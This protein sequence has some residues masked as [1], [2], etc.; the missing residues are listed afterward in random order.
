MSLRSIEEFDLKSKNL[1]LRLDLNV[2]LNEGE[3]TDETRIMAALPTIQY[4]IDKGAKIVL[5]SH[6]GRPKTDEDRKK[7]SLQPVAERLGELLN[8]EVLLVEEPNGDA[9]KALLSN[10]KPNQLILLENLR[11]IP[12][13]TKNEKS[14]S[15][16]WAQFTDVYIN[17]AFGASHREHAS[18]VGLPK[19][20]K[21]HGV[22]FLIKKEVEMLNKVLKGDDKPFV[23]VLGGAK[24][25]DKITV[26]EALVNK[27]DT[28]IIG[29]AMAYTFLAAKGIC[30]GRSLVEK[31]KIHLA[32]EL[33]NRFKVRGKELLLPMDH[34]VVS[35]IEKPGTAL[36]TEND[37]IKDGYMGVDIGP[38]TMDYFCDVIKNAGMVFW[39]GPMGIFETPEYSKGTF[40]IAEAMANNTG[41]T[42]VG[43]GDSA[44]A[45][46]KSGFS[47]KVTHVSTGGGASLEYIE[48]GHLPGIDILK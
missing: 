13:E 10:L 19:L 32:K 40:A 17:D 42:I 46:A 9:P 34:L 5:A 43:G 2:P 29:G 31:D 15:E 44:A 38:K 37:N 11:F 4:A 27:V 24:V 1:F 7:L 48:L 23:T 39:N 6:L 20:V 22:G 16:K 21:N 25:S 18:I 45:I 36:K 30:V 26:I 41:L 8:I 47:Q 12:A 3:I 35:A 28:L 33:L 14:L